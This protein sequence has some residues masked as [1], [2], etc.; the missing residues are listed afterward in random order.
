M[1][2]SAGKFRGIRSLSVMKRIT[3]SVALPVLKS[4]L[5]CTVF[6]TL[7]SEWS[8]LEIWHNLFIF[9]DTCKMCKWEWSV[10]CLLCLHSVVHSNGIREQFLRPIIYRLRIY[11][12]AF[13]SNED[14]ISL[15]C[16]VNDMP[17]CRYWACNCFKTA[18]HTAVKIAIS[19]VSCCIQCWIVCFQSYLL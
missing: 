2:Y 15:Q 10:L 18:G 9:I 11:V 7:Y 17:C 19:L 1:P 5:G 16:L 14:L 12:H 8:L 3:L 13:P 4:G 6:L